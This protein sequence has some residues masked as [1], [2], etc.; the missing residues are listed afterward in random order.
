MHSNLI[1][2]KQH[3]I[4]NKRQLLKFT[5]DMSLANIPMHT[6]TAPASKASFKPFDT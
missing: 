2:Y 5:S 1:G 4:G 6:F 3:I